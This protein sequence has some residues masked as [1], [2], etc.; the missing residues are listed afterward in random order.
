M[1]KQEPGI[2]LIKKLKM[3]ICYTRQ[4]GEAEPETSE[5]EDQEKIALITA[6]QVWVP[7]LSALCKSQ[8]I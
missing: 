1:R 6:E 3:Q 7:P 8:V 5:D 4:A 2:E